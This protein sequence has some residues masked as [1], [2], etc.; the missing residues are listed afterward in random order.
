MTSKNGRFHSAD[1]E[2]N[3]FNAASLPVSLDVGGCIRKIASIFDG[4]ASMPFFDTR[5][6]RNFP[7]A[8]LKMLFFRVEFEACPSEVYECFSEVCNMI[9]SLGASDDDGIHM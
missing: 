4:L 5:Q 7:F 9:F 2:M 6:P 3:L 8:I 1:L